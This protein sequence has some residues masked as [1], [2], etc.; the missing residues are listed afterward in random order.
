MNCRR[1]R[2]KNRFPNAEDRSDAGAHG[3][4]DDHGC[5][6]HPHAGDISD[7][8]ERP[9]TKNARGDADVARARAWVLPEQRVG[10]A[11]AA[12][13]AIAV[14]TMNVLRARLKS[15]ERM[16]TIRLSY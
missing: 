4:A 10:D 13:V 8:I 5:M 15:G 11:T 1:T 2:S 3:V 7:G 16:G 12:T 14:R 9:R 6:T